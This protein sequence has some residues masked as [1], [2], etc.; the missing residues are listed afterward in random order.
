MNSEQRVVQP[1]HDDDP[2]GDATGPAQIL[3]VDDDTAFLTL[4]RILLLAEFP[5][6]VIRSAMNGLAAL[7]SHAHVRADVIVADY[8]MPLM[9][10]IELVTHLRAQADPVPIIIV[11]SEPDIAAEALGAGATA[12]LSKAKAGSDLAP[13]LACLLPGQEG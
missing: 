1:N 8:R 4:M 2:A 3:L 13:L 12:F 5:Q 6:A 9:D 7:A 10:G 11:S